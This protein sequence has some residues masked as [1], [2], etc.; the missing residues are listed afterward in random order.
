MLSY[1]LTCFGY[2]FIH[3]YNR[4]DLCYLFVVQI[5]EENIGFSLNYLNGI[6]TRS[7][8][9]RYRVS[10]SRI[11]SKENKDGTMNE[12]LSDTSHFCL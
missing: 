10:D 3:L 2:V 8:Y 5:L 9:K 12:I 4:L 7:T 11:R 6:R 1:L